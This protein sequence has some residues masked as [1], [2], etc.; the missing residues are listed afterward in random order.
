MKLI[1]GDPT[2]ITQTGRE[3]LYRYYTEKF[4]LGRETGVELY[5]NLGLIGDP[6]EGD[7]RDSLYANMT[8]GQNLMVTMMQVISGYNVLVN[9]GNMWSRRL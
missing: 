8:F 3:M 7:G 5:E 1:G 2:Q 6:N 9:G 4:R